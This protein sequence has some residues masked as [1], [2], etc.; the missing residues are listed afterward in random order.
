MLL[1]LFLTYIIFGSFQTL[2]EPLLTSLR[3]LQSGS[4]SSG[5]RNTSRGSG[6]RWGG[7]GGGGPSNG[8]GSGGRLV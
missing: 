7:S 8:P 3:G 6:S 1:I 5:G 2:A 4:M